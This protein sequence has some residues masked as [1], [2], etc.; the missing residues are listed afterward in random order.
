MVRF[1]PHVLSF[2]Q[3]EFSLSSKKVRVADYGNDGDD[4][5]T[6]FDG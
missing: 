1:L 2:V 3:H 6:L 4:D 5:T